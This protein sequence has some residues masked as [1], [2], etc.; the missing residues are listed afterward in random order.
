[1]PTNAVAVTEYL[2]AVC[3]KVFDSPDELHAGS[4]IGGLDN[5]EYVCEDCVVTCDW[6]NEVVLRV[7]R[8]GYVGTRRTGTG[9]Y[10]CEDCWDDEAV[11]CEDCAERYREN[12]TTFISGSDT[13]VCMGCRD[14]NYYYCD[15]CDTHYREGDGCNCTE[16]EEECHT[17]PRRWPIQVADKESLHPTLLSLGVE[18]EYEYM[19]HDRN[20]VNDAAKA[21][22]LTA[23]IKGDGSLEDG[24]EWCSLPATWQRWCADK[25]RVM[26]GLV[27]LQRT[28]ARSHEPATCGLHIHMRRSAWTSIT[29]YK[30]LRLIYGDPAFTL[31][32]SRRARN[33][34]AQ[35][36]ALEDPAKIARKA[37]A[38]LGENERSERYVA[39]NLDT[40]HN[41]IELRFFR[42]TL[43]AETFWLSL[44]FAAAAWE[45][46][47]TAPMALAGSTH[48][49]QWL[50]ALEPK[51]YPELR[52][53]LTKKGLNV[54]A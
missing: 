28:G 1:M 42:G 31:A 37:M 44:E 48:F 40:P 51:Q 12:D 46:A 39:V 34:L 6:C 49:R 18:L 38:K 41:T 54:C 19:G 4:D 2:C 32:L 9:E 3:G 22:P 8:R 50:T 14:N 10:I 45:W 47:Q 20:L 26:A 15:D 5:E 43:K 13:R 11:I 52:T 16:V 33:K 23:C 27:A 21:L 29:I 35:W 7:E 53:W 17:P 36:A 25:P 30:L 24:Q